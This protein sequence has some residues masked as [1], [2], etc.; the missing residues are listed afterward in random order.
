M[1]SLYA[2]KLQGKHL[3]LALPAHRRLLAAACMLAAAAC[4]A[5]FHCA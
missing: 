4:F 3:P 1:E 2:T 5:S